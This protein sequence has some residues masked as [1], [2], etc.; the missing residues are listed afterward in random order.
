MLALRRWDYPP[1]SD[2]VRPPKL[3]AVAPAPTR[4]KSSRSPRAETDTE[5]KN[6]SQRIKKEALE[7]DQDFTARD[8]AA[9][10]PTI[11]AERPGLISVVLNN[12]LKRGE[13]RV[14]SQGKGSTPTTYAPMPLNS[15][16]PGPQAAA[17]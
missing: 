11:H 6:D 7:R 13:L 10:L 5:P 9:Q 12:L 1:P 17:R 4:A 8:L 16:R 3:R 14:V 15:L 2:G